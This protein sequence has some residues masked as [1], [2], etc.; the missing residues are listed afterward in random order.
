MEIALI[1]WGIWI[2][3]WVPVSLLSDKK[4]MWTCLTSAVA[5]PFLLVGFALLLL[6]MPVM[7]IFSKKARNI[8]TSKM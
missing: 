5:T 3:L 7:C 2:L 4:I 8:F 1:I 6:V